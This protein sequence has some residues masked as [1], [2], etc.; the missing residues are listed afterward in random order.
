MCLSMGALDEGH[1]DVELENGVKLGGCIE[2]GFEEQPET[3]AIEDAVRVLLHGLGEDVNREGIRKTPF[4]V[5]KALREGT[6][7]DFLH[8]PFYVFYPI[9]SPFDLQLKSVSF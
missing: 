4:R 5:A 7:G 1:F 6:R 8:S 2:L 9:V 3:L